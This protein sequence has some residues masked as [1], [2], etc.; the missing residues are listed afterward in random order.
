MF[1]VYYSNIEY[2]INVLS[3]LLL[4]ECIINKYVLSVL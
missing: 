4:L 2:I 1:Q 3:V